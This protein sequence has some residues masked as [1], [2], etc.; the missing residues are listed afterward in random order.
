MQVVDVG[1]AIGQRRDRAEVVAMQEVDVGDATGA[2]TFGDDR[3]VERVEGVRV[4][5]GQIFDIERADVDRRDCLARELEP[6]AIGVVDVGFLDAVGAG[7]AGR[8]LLGFRL[9]W[10]ADFCLAINDPKRANKIASSLFIVK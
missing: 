3:A 2:T 5:A 8:L 1:H 7:D 9:F 6:C 10:G 4:A